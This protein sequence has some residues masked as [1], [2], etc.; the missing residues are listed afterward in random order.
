MC[1][2]KKGDKC[3]HDVVAMS[4][5]LLN[6]QEHIIPMKDINEL[7]NVLGIRF[8]HELGILGVRAIAKY[9]QYIR[10]K[11]VDLSFT[12]EEGQTAQHHIAKCEYVS[13]M[14]ELIRAGAGMNAADENGWTPLHYAIHQDLPVNVQIL[15]D[16]GADIKLGTTTTIW[17]PY[18][19]NGC[20]YVQRNETLVSH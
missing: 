1:A 10:L 14:L 6:R 2:T 20:H 13:F 11:H 9:V 4:L 3:T 16:H 7:R 18:G 8:V 12:D 15:L 17:V 5:D 19:V